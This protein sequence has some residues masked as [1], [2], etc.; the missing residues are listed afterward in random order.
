M[1]KARKQIQQGADRVIVSSHE[2]AKTVVQELWNNGSRI[3]GGLSAAVLHFTYEPYY[4]LNRRFR[5][6]NADDGQSDDVFRLIEK[7]S[8]RSKFMKTISKYMRDQD[9]SV[10]SASSDQEESESEHYTDAS[11]SEFE[12]ESYLDYVSTQYRRAKAA[13]RGNILVRVASVFV[14]VFVGLLSMIVP[15]ALLVSKDPQ[16]SADGTQP[17]HREKLYHNYDIS[18]MQQGSEERS[19][20]TGLFED[21]R[22]S[23]MLYIDHMMEANRKLVGS[24]IE[25]WNIGQPGKT[26]TVYWDNLRSY[27]S[28]VWSGFSV[29]QIKTTPPSADTRSTAKKFCEAAGY[30]FESHEATTKD[31]YI[32][33]LSRLPRRESAKVVYMQHGLLDNSVA[34]VAGGSLG[35]PAFRAYE[36][37]YD[38]WFGS[39]RGNGSR[40][41]IIS[42]I[43]DVDYWDYSV[44]EHAFYDVPAFIE[45][46]RKVKAEEAMDPDCRPVSCEDN[47]S[48]A[49]ISN[50]GASSSRGRR[51]KRRTRQ[52]RAAA[53]TNAAAASTAS[54]SGVSQTGSDAADAGHMPAFTIDDIE[55]TAIGH[56]M[57]AA[58]LPMYLV[59]YG[60]QKLDHHLK[61]LILLSPA[62][63]H[64]VVPFHIRCGLYF[65]KYVLARLFHSLRLPYDYL[66]LLFAKLLSDA[67]K[68]P[69]TIDLI[70][71]LSSKV[72][73]GDMQTSF[74]RNIDFFNYKLYGTSS[75]VFL[76]GMMCHERKVFQTYDYGP[77]RNMV[78]YGQP[79]T[80]KILDEY[81]LIDVPIHFVFGEKDTIIHPRDA[82]A[83]YNAL[84]KHHPNLARAKRYPSLGHV[85]FTIGVNAD[86]IDYVLKTI[87]Q[88]D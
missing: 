24:V 58:V 30:P 15:P 49:S 38:V 53:S 37:G 70:S 76:H 81:N 40:D 7:R 16:P 39:F 26:A 31:G 41:H 11:D 61:K 75:K 87:A 10:H 56:S 79:T 42:N 69:E 64:T 73:G 9:D 6:K 43:S 27:W 32:L 82:L 45:T 59:W 35:S 85:D 52:R 72:V 80:I 22:L 1:G 14:D 36:A 18:M 34:W 68:S 71:V 77:E 65:T 47:S 20:M 78:E 50:N 54:D 60:R 13:H 29:F 86:V 48:A 21:I 51:N 44:N 55:I 5:V 19:N 84:A 88:K 57:G 4:H 28:N 3:L 83:H 62:G 17:S 25:H 66:H 23:I 74:M 67:K 63:V 33:E 46:I 8:G 12:V 2:S